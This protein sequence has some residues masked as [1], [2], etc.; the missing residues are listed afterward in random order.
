MGPSRG[1]GADRRTRDAK[2]FR[3]LGRNGGGRGAGVDGELERPTAV[4]MDVDENERLGRVGQTQGDFGDR[5]RLACQLEAFWV[6]QTN[7]ALAI[8]QRDPEM[9][10][11][12]VAEVAVDFSADH[13]ANVAQ[14]D[15]A[16]VHIVQFG[17]THRERTQLCERNGNRASRALTLL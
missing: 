13:F 17:R 15:Q 10:E 5:R 11:E 14:V 4:C 6:I 3:Q 9:L 16:Y 12:I 2:F 8:V 7:L 1:G